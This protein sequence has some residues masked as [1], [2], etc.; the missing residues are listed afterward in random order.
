LVRQAM[1]GAF[2]LKVPLV[3]DAKIG[4]NWYDMQ[5]L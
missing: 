5:K 4:E 1:E 3:A 2:A